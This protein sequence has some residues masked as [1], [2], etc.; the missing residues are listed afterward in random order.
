MA[1]AKQKFITSM[2]KHYRDSS[3]P[4]NHSDVLNDLTARVRSIAAMSANK[5]SVELFGS[6]I[7]GFCKPT[8]DAD[9]SFT[10]RNFSHWL[11]GISRVDDQ[12]GKRLIRFSKEA[13]AQG[14]TN[15]RYIPARIPVVQM[16]DS[17]TDIHCDVSIGNVGGVENSKILRMVHDI[18]P[19]LIGAYIHIVKEWGK[20][21]EVIAP[22]KATFNSFTVTTMALMVLQELGLVPVMHSPTGKFGELTVEDAAKHLESWK[23]PPI[24][25]TLD[26]DEKLGE[27]VLFL[28]QK[29]AEYYT[30]FDFKTGSVSLMYPRRLRT[31]YG[32]I[33]AKH[34]ELFA[35]H[36]RAEWEQH[37]R[38]HPADGS[39]DADEFSAAMQNE[40]RQRV[41]TSPYVVEDFVNYVNCGRR[42]VAPRVPM[43]TKELQR[44]HDMLLGEL[45]PFEEVVKPTTQK[46][47]SFHEASDRRV[48]TFNDQL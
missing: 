9:F 30:R 15:V 36:K 21:R 16:V 39:F 46:L 14:F 43:I 41:S 20:A 2:M 40:A 42:V 34:L 37:H 8:S 12:N 32:E 29:F 31:L 6:Y 13:A 33:V 48:M 17:V 7:S 3:L 4:I 5:A 10:Y 24:Y 45:Q 25:E 28:W 27:A 47:R 23:L 11:Q 38:E 44:L 35:E 1:S 19:D 22:D 26:T 18:H